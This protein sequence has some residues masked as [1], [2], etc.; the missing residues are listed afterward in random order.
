MDCR[1]ATLLAMTRKLLR[2]YRPKALPRSGA[3]VLLTAMLA[4]APACAAAGPMIPHESC[5]DQRDDDGERRR[6]NYRSP[7]LRKKS[8]HLITPPSP[9]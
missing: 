8:A 3:A 6:H 7:L 5:H 1:M 9:P 4:S 2:L